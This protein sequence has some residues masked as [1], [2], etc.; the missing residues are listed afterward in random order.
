MSFRVNFAL[1]ALIGKIGTLSGTVGK[2]LSQ[3]IIENRTS[4]FETEKKEE[5][6]TLEKI[7]QQDI[8][9]F[10]TEHERTEKI[11]KFYNKYKICKKMIEILNI[12]DS[13]RDSERKGRTIEQ[14][15]LDVYGEFAEKIYSGTRQEQWAYILAREIEC[16]GSFSRRTLRVLFE[17]DAETA[18]NF[19]S[20][21]K[22]RME[23]KCVIKPKG[24]NGADLMKWQS[25]ID[26]GLLHD[27]AVFGPRVCMKEQRRNNESKALSYVETGDMLLR[28]ESRKKAK[29][30]YAEVGMLKQAGREIGK[31]L[32][33]PEHES[34]LKKFAD[35]IKEDCDVMILYKLVD[36]SVKREPTY[37]QVKKLK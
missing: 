12:R 32:P 10:I 19:Q 4:I 3:K 26:A 27:I 34:I 37:V 21:M 9:A 14:D 23:N 15:W 29:D 36:Q 11:K 22:H 8:E 20:I 18:K 30:L 2:M 33:E 5:K 17:L 1:N 24:L 7:K 28:V 31:I 35:Y 6:G 16:P 25:V 13:G